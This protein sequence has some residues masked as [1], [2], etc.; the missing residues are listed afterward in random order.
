MMRKTLF[1]IL[2][3]TFFFIFIFGE[4]YKIGPG[5]VLKIDVIGES[6]F[7]GTFTVNGDG[8]ITLKYIGDFKV[9][10]LTIDEVKKKLYT[11]LNKDYI[12]NPNIKIKI[13]EYKSKKIVVLGE[14]NRPGEYY[15]KKNRITILEVI[16]MAGGL[17]DNCGNLAIVFR[18]VKGKTE[19]KKIEI[20][21]GDILSGIEKP[22]KIFIYPDDI[23][24]FPKKR[25]DNPN[26]KVY[27]EGKVVKPG[28]YKYVK[29]MTVYQLCLEAGGFA[30]FSAENRAY[31]IRNVKGKTVKIKVNLKKVRK[32]KA[33][34]INLKPG[35]RVIIPSSW[36]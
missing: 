2:I 8:N 22:D 7:S 6:D 16:S 32:G 10:G 14:V 9:G 5:D 19:F 18:K 35:D 12:N 33:K 17:S 3:F 20:K 1:F 30:E 21:I 26:L 24:N 25:E 27:I 31:I 13:L 34:D 29:G 36:F 28:A 11:I 4:G 23:I 15:L